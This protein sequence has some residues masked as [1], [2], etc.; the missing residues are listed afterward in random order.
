MGLRRGFADRPNAR[1]RSGGAGARAGPLGQPGRAMTF[2]LDHAPALVELLEGSGVVICHE[3]L[4][5]HLARA[6]VEIEAPVRRETG[7]GA[8]DD[9]EVENTTANAK[10]GAKA[11][12]K[13]KSR[14]LVGMLKSASFYP[15]RDFDIPSFLANPGVEIAEE[16]SEASQRIDQPPGRRP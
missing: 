3:D 11:I 2:G 10:A 13:A 4:V 12:G 6:I 5:V 1:R 9:W 8:V 15:K 14:Y 16:P 7:A